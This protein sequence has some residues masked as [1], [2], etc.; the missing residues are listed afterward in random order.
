LS[1]E[2]L[3]GDVS[4]QFTFG[5]EEDF[6]ASINAAREEQ[7]AIC[8]YP[9]MLVKSRQTHMKDVNGND[10]YEVY[11]TFG[12]L[13]PPPTPEELAAAG[14]TTDHPNGLWGRDENGQLNPK[15]V[16]PPSIGTVVLSNIPD[17]TQVR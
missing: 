8:G 6:A 9:L 13:P 7:E 16:P 3:G 15:P 2:T 1:A 11:A 12:P 17:G 4:T 10:V 5:R 14:D